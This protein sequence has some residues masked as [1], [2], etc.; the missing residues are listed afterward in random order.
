ML[1]ESNQSQKITYCMIP[2]LQNVQSRQ[3]QR[4]R[5]QICGYQ[6]GGRGKWRATATECQLYFEGEL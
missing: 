5:K 3:I 2:L 6:T 1:G 4:D